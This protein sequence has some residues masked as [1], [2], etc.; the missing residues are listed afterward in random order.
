VPDDESAALLDL[1]HRLAVE[2]AALLRDGAGPLRHIENKSSATDLVTEMDRAAERLIVDGIVAARPDDGVVGE[3]GS[4]RPGTSGVR[5]L[6]DPL[7]GTTNYVYGFPGFAVSI[8]AERHDPR[9]PAPPAG[10]GRLVAG[11]VA[12]VASG[13]VFAARAGAGAT[14]NGHAVHCSGRAELAA[15]LVA[16]GFSYEAARRARQAQ[17]LTMVLPRVRDIRRMGAA[18]LDLCSVACGRVDAF[19]EKGLGPWDF[20]A[21]ALIAAEAGAVVG[22]LDGGGPSGA[23]VLAAPPPLAAP[24]RELLRSAGAADA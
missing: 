7:D 13:D 2:A 18:A 21:G 17:V 12:D 23:F 19:Y 8:A 3:E 22:D 14:R 15:A 16:T 5:W 6:V 11:V 1:A 20:A 24:L 9:S 4:S 10:A